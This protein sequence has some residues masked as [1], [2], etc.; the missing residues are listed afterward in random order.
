L[1]PKLISGI[2]EYGIPSL[3]PIELGDLIVPGSRTGQGFKISLHDI[4]AYGS[5]NWKITRLK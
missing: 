5:S 3:E 1:N 2:P 4:K